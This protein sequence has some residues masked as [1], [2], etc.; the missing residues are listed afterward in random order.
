MH[1]EAVKSQT[2]EAQM[3]EKNQ[4][5]E[6][7]MSDTQILER[8]DLRITL[9]KRGENAYVKQRRP[10]TY[11]LYHEVETP[12]A[13]LLFNL[14]G[15]IIRAEGRGGAWPS[16]LEYLRRTAGDDWVYYSTGGYGGSWETLTES[17]FPAQVSFRI[18]EPYSEVFKTFGEYYLPNLPYASNAILGTDP[19]AIPA[20]QALLDGWCDEVQAVRRKAN[21]LPPQFRAFLGRVADNT[22]QRLRQKAK[23]LFAACGGRA[24]VLPPDARHVDYNV[25]PLNISQGCLYKCR[26]CTVKNTMPFRTRSRADIAGQLDQL[27]ALYGRDLINYN[28]VFLGDHDAL[29]ADDAT[30]LWAIGQAR[31]RLGIDRSYMQGASVFLFGSVTSLMAKDDAFFDRLGTCGASVY[32]NVG[33]ESVDQQTL[34]F[35]GKPLRSA[36]VARC[37]ERMQEISAR[38][39]SIEC[40]ANFVFDEA[41]PQGHI[42]AFLELV[43]AAGG[44]AQAKGTVYMSPLCLSPPSAR[45]LFEL[46][47]LKTWSRLP[48]YLYLIQR[49]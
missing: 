13:R 14:E 25:I 10:V 30:I 35:I 32:I 1:D 8:G 15:D 17:P 39:A 44:S 23:R 42:P 26:F 28:A 36:Q 6:T 27:A 5:P 47:Q 48:L 18:P 3:P 21:D 29:G 16:D 7:Q 31:E 34:D 11:G 22:P 12:S 4:M 38:H 49:L 41:L 46:K 2:P 19:F 45:T 33:L 37:F 40:T 43:G 24:S 20:V 9:H